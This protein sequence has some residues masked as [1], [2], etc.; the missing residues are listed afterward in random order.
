MISII[1]PA[2]NES[3]MLPLFFTELSNVC[4]NSSI[5]YE[6]IFVDDGSQ[7]NTWDIILQ[8][9]GQHNNIHGIRFSRNFGKESAIYAG[10]AKCTGEAA[11][12]MDADLQHPPKYIPEM[13]EY[14]Y[15]GYSIVQCIKKK[16]A[17]DEC[18]CYKILAKLFY[19]CFRQLVPQS[20]DISSSS[21]FILLDRKILKEVLNFHEK[22]FFFR[23][24]VSS[25]GYERAKIEFE[26]EPRQFGETKWSY[27]NLYKYAISNIAAFTA[28]PLQLVTIS[29]IVLLITACCLSIRSIYLFLNNRAAPGISTVIILLCVI[30]SGIML[31]LGIIG[32]Y[33]AK[34]YEEVKARPRYLIQDS[35][36]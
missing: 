8:L 32:Y 2:Y 22:Y 24:I 29:G 3:K 27:L 10:L 35:I 9:S 11:I 18:V 1:V 33:I 26:V 17:T 20:I 28:K 12:V 6:L 5:D 19:A 7:D 4:I 31:S 16:R 30:G 25:I 15:S 36:P 23:G 34:I 21:D 14:Y 13:I